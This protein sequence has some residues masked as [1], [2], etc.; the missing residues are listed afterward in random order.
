MI[1][2]SLCSVCW[3]G[4]GLRLTMKY[5]HLHPL[6]QE[7]LESS[8]CLVVRF[9]PGKMKDVSCTVTFAPSHTPTTCG[10]S[11]SEMQFC[12]KEEVSLAGGVDI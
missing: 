10:I 12:G 5:R 9:V 1:L 3:G 8:Y 2:F 6:L 11:T 7:S 4:L